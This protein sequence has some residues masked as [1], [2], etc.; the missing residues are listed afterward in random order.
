MCNI[1]H[2]PLLHSSSRLLKKTQTLR[3]ELVRTKTDARS[4]GCTCISDWY[5]VRRAAK[6]VLSS[7]PSCRRPEVELFQCLISVS[8]I[9]NDW[10]TGT[11]LRSILF[12]N[13][14]LQSPGSEMV[15]K[16]HTHTQVNGDPWPLDTHKYIHDTHPL[17]Y[18]CW[19]PHVHHAKALGCMC[20]R[21]C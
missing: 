4:H 2:T 11:E 9:P 21:R 1:N 16:W 12:H 19:P 14:H 20:A 18:Q 5:C 7:D 17:I 15:P 13:K 8:L 3:A 10:S 6:D